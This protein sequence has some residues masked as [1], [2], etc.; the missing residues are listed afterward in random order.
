MRAIHSWWAILGT[1][2]GNIQ[3]I[4]TDVHNTQSQQ[5]A[6]QQQVALTMDA[7]IQ[8]GLFVKGYV[9][10]AAQFKD[11]D[12][13]CSK[14]NLVNVYEWGW[15]PCDDYMS[16]A[17]ANA[18]QTTFTATV[19][20]VL[21]MTID[22]PHQSISLALSVTRALTPHPQCI[23]FC[24][25]GGA[26][27]GRLRLHALGLRATAGGQRGPGPLRGLREPARRARHLLQRAGDGQRRQG[28]RGRQG[29]RLPCRHRA[30]VRGHR[31]ARRP[32][33]GASFVHPVCPT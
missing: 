22:Q 30:H 2:Y 6:A 26:Q 1:Q 20:F 16:A 28:H 31:Q 13:A 32:H 21:H 19:R 5:H 4:Y 24:L 27:G 3:Y 18:G 9:F 14:G 10:D 7:N 15:G 8:G 33:H 11:F 29:H 17:K 12:A 23:L 25:T